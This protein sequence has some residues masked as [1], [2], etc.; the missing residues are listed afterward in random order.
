MKNIIFVGG[1]HGV[2]KGTFC[3]LITKQTGIA[4]YS[5]GKLLSDAKSDVSI[6]KRTSNSS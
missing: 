1:I 2:G 6:S 3:N 5:S 4:N